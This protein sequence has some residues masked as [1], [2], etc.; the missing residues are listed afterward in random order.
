M[1]ELEVEFAFPE[2]VRRVLELRYKEGPET[3]GFDQLV[4]VFVNNCRILA[5]TIKDE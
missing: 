1:H 2:Q 5:R 3:F 4:A